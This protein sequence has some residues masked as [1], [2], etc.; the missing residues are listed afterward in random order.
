[1]NLRSGAGTVLGE[2]RQGRKAAY[3]FRVADSSRNCG[4]CLNALQS[5]QMPATSGGTEA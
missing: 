5:G 1:M 2:C 3:R 4:L